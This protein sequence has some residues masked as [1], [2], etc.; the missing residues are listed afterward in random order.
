MSI[1]LSTLQDITISNKIRHLFLFIALVALDV[2]YEIVLYY[3]STISYHNKNKSKKGMGIKMNIPVF[4][5][6]KRL[7]H[8]L[9]EINAVYHEIALKLGLSDSAMQ[10]LY[11]ICDY[12]GSC[13]LWDI[14]R[15]S[16]LSKQ[17]VHSAIRK[18]EQENIVSVSKTEKRLKMVTLTQKGSELVD[19]TVLP[20]MEKENAILSSWSKEDVEKYL[21]LTQRYLYDLR[22]QYNNI[23]T[24]GGVMK[25]E[26]YNH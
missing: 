2:W 7:N 15:F 13:L 16:G 18:L 14:S 24:I 21:E 12:Q 6:N 25:I 23:E 20:V 10:I 8:L 5:E 22:E 26:D 9:G 3:H 11:M 1:I 4:K 17:T 19:K